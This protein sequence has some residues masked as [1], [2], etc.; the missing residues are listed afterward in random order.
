MIKTIISDLGKVILPFDNGIF[1]RR[2]TAYC[3]HSEEEIS[4]IADANQD[5]VLL[6]D[7]GRIGPEEFYALVTKNLDARIGQETFFAIYN[8]VFSLNSEVLAVLRKAKNAGCRMILLSNTDPRR[9]PFIA[10]KYPEIL[11]FDDY[12]L[13]YEVKM[14]K[15]DPG[16]YR[17]ALKRADAPAREC[18]FIDD[19]EE[20]VK[21]AE[22][23]GMQ[24]VH[25]TPETDLESELEK[26]G[27]VLRGR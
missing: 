5:W 20:N 22:K 24:T 3:P 15:P 21:A 9:Y 14:I 19:I 10:G 11:I 12:V 4:E 23:L 8:D 13:S 27:L 6:F 7:G 25:F 17:A 18:V 16:I 26:R 2:M 1:F